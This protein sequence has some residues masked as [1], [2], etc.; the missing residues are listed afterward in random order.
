MNKIPRK[1]FFHSLPVFSDAVRRELAEG[2]RQCGKTIVVLDDDPTGIQTVHGIN[3]YMEWSPAVLRVPLAG[4]KL[5]F[6]HTNTRAFDAGRTERINREATANV[7]GVAKEL[8]KEVSFISR[9]DS[10][11]RGHY[12]LETGTIRGAYEEAD[13]NP[14]DGEIF[15]P[16]FEEGGRFTAN[17][18]HYVMQD[19]ELVP[20]GETEFARDST[21][22]YRSSNLKDYIAEKCGG[23]CGKI[24]SISL[25][26]LR[27]QGRTA[28][29]EFLMKAEGFERIIVN[30]CGYDDLRIFSD[31]LEAAEAAGK[32]FIFRS[33]ASFVKVYGN[34]PEKGFLEKGEYA[35]LL[36]NCSA[37]GLVVVGSHVNKTTMQLK[38]LMD[39]GDVSP[40]EFR[41]NELDSGADAEIRRVASAADA[42]IASGK[43]PLVFTS[44]AIAGTG[45]GREDRLR[46]SAK[47]SNALAGAIRLMGARPSFI[48][49]K[50]GITSSDIAT[51]GLGVKKEYVVGQVLGGGSVVLLDNGC[52]WGGLP[53]AIFPGNVGGADALLEVFSLFEEAR[54][55]RNGQ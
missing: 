20:A 36:D 47:I 11:L 52:K 50:G 14:V 17:D 44:R 27:T 15:V 9:G 43:T 42:Q 26:L 22:A 8:G 10:T 37:P 2:G 30:A 46:I 25:E 13:G 55:W 32:R 51:K 33:A 34:L 31:G 19:D 21:F 38:R 4:E 12:P 16:F 6:I 35:R 3:V 49:A 18:I 39:E 28:V 5:F 53:Y 1:D 7:L 24:S 40:V 48:I 41:V 23:A 45:G 29:K 54:K